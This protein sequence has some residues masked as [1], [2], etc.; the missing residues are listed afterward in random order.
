MEGISG[1]VG[2]TLSKEDGGYIV[3]LVSALKPG[4]QDA[5]AIAD[6][7]VSAVGKDIAGQVVK[8]LGEKLG[9]E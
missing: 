3:G 7:V 8:A 5:A 4:S 1:Q 2:N 6:A 9:S